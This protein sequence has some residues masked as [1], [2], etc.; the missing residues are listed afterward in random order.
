MRLVVNS[1]SSQPEPSVAQ[2]ATLPAEANQ[3]SPAASDTTNIQADYRLV[4]LPLAPPWRIL[5][6]GLLLQITY[7]RPRRRTT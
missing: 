2:L 3:D 1:E 5:K 4:F 6:R 7:N